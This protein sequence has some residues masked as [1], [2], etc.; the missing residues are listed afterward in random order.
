[1]K[2]VIRLTESDLIQLVKRVIKEQSSGSSCTSEY[3]EA[4]GSDLCVG[5]D[6]GMTDRNSIDTAFKIAEAC[7]CLSPDNEYMN[8]DEIK[9]ADA[10]GKIRDRQT[11]QNVNAILGCLS[12]VQGFK[13]IGEKPIQ[14]L[15]SMMM[16]SWEDDLKT[17]VSMVV[18]KFQ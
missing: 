14:K 16:D 12:S 8:W 1:M 3:P 4:F 7:G 5:E 11:F 18:K 2:K 17:K 9:F 15:S 10:V 6:S 13:T